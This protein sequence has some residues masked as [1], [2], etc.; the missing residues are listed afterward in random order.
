MKIVIHNG[1]CVNGVISRTIATMY[2]KVGVRNLSICTD[3]HGATSV[4]ELYEDKN[5]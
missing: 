2:A 4:I 5:S 3:G 1:I